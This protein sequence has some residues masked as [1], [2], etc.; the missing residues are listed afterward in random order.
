MYFSGLAIA[1]ALVFARRLPE[2]R[3]HQ[4]TSFF[5]LEPRICPVVALYTLTRHAS[6][7]TVGPHLVEGQYGSPEC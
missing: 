1:C 3:L 7:H 4:A 6:A 2:R 5:D